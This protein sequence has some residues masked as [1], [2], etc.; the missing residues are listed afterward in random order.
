MAADGDESSDRRGSPR[1]R[2]SANVAVC[3]R[4]R[5]RG[6]NRRVRG[7]PRSAHNCTRETAASTQGYAGD[8]GLYRRV[9]GRPRPAHKCTRE[10]AAS[11]RP[12]PIQKGTRET[13]AS[14]YAGA[15]DRSQ[16]TITA[17]T[18]VQHYG[19]IISTKSPATFQAATNFINSIRQTLVTPSSL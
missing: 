9:R 3:T 12:R 19:S 13:A 10:T 15:G 4:E 17:T 2:F 11:G 8:R 1:T 6:Q 7:R 18:F 5:D 14:T 16:Y